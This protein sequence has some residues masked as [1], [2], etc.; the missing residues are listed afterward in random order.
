MSKLDKLTALLEAGGIVVAPTTS[1]L[2]F[3][4]GKQD[5]HAG[6]N[7]H[8]GWSEIAKGLGIDAWMRT[9]ARERY[10]DGWYQG[11]AAK[12]NGKPLHEVLPDA[13]EGRAEDDDADE[14]RAH[15]LDNEGSLA[16]CFGPAV[17]SV[18]RSFIP[19]CT[20]DEV[21]HEVR[22]PTEFELRMTAI[23]TDRGF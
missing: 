1:R 13:P 8:S 11:R 7:M 6:T 12:A 23:M 4:N 15:E 9:P 2:L 14:E 3:A 22:Q 17:P 19:A 10:E 16:R 5:G 21:E 18:D 20:A